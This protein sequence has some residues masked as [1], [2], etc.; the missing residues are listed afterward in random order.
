MGQ[1]YSAELSES[2]SPNTVIKITPPIEVFDGD[3]GVN[4]EIEFTC[5]QN[6]TLHEDACRIFTVSTERIS[7]GR[8]Y[9]IITLSQ[10]LDF[11]TSPIYVLTLV[12]TDGSIVNPM[13]SSTDITINVLDVQDQVSAA[14]G[15]L[16]H[17]F[18]AR[19]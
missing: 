14:S 8:F 1:P 13:S 3:E 4:A 2:L 18:R 5:L 10:R 9:A 19:C 6:T 17:I 11:E 12:A 16:L 7:E 15:Y